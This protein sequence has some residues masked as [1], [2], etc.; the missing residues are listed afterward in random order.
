MADTFT[1]PGK[2][3]SGDDALNQAVDAMK[4]FGKKAFIVTD[5][6]M[7]QIGNL[8]QLTLC[9]D[10]AEIPYAVYSGINHEPDDR[11]INQ[12]L[13]LYQQEGCDYFVA[14]GG[15]SPIDSMKAIALLSVCE[16]KLSDFMGKII[17]EKLPPMTAIPTTAGTG[18]EATQFTII[19]DTESQVK[20]LLKGPSLMPDL[21]VVDAKLTI[22]VPPGITAATGMDALCHAVE[23]F[24]SI[25]AQNLSDT[26]AL[27]AIKR[28]FRYLPEAYKNGENE[29]ART[30]MS[31]ASLEAGIA[32][33][34]SSVTLI[35]GM[36]RPIGARFHIAHGI[37]NAV[38]MQEC[39]SFALEGAYDRFAVLGRMTGAADDQD[40]DREAS[41]KFLS[42]LIDLTETL[43]IPT[44]KK[45]GIEQGAFFDA[46]EKMSDDAMTSGSPQNTRRAVTKNDI[47]EIYQTLWQKGQVIEHELHNI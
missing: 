34:N 44:I 15:G 46:I 28:I 41:E 17:E 27:S 14:L 31:L 21:A 20:M 26:F 29:E 11:M 30:Q 47:K 42:A 7:I 45:L 12:G 40:N 1:V 6:T 13:K 43:N 24:T 18:S 10:K 9:L 32:F 22:T 2:I 5:E 35:H 37:S 16:K 23:A 25:K 8:E 33:N 36:S 39:L 3:I 38:L 19:T 4:D